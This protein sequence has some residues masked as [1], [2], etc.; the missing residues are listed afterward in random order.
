MKLDWQRPGS[1]KGISH[2]AQT[3]FSA[4]LGSGERQGCEPMSGGARAGSGSRKD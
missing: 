3:K 4:E 2:H 1:F